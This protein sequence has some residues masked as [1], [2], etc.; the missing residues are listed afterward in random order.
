M[1]NMK[2]GYPHIDKPW[3]KFYGEDA[4]Y[5]DLPQTNLT[6]YLKMRNEGRMGL[7]AETYYGKKFT[8]NDLFE[9]SDE[10]ATIFY[11]LGI[12]PGESI[13]NLVPNIPEAGHLLN[14]ATEV[15]IISNFID[16]RPDTP[17][18]VANARKVLELIKY[19][20]PKYIIA[21]DMA[22]L[23]AIRPIE[24]ELKEYGVDT[25]ILLSASDSMNLAGKIDYLRDVIEYNRLKNLR[26]AREL[27]RMAQEDLEK[28]EIKKLKWYEALMEKTQSMKKSGSMLE[29]AIKASPLKIYRY[30]D[31]VRD[32]RHST[33]ERVL[34]PYAI[35]YVGHTSGTSG[36]RPKP[37]PATNISGISAL[38]QLRRADVGYKEKDNVLHILPYFAPFGKY[39][40]YD[41]HLAFGANVISIPEF[42]IA[43][44]GYLIKKYHPN[45]IVA[46]PAWISSLVDCEYLQNIDLSCITRI[47]YG[48]DALA[49]QREEVINEW[50]REHGSKATLEKGYGMSETLGCC[51]YA[52]KDYNT[53]GSIGIPLPNTTFAIVDPN[54]EDRLVPLKFEEGKDLLTGELV[55]SSEALTTGKLNGEVIVPHYKLDGKDCIR[56]RDIVH[57]NRDGIFF[58]EERKDRSFV[59]FDGFKVK[60]Y[61]IESKILEC[62]S[63]EDVC[64]VD[65]FDDRRRGNMPICHIVPKDKSVL[66]DDD[67]CVNIV[68]DIVYNY[69]I[70]DPQMSSRQIPAKF[71][72]HA[73]LPLTMSSKTNFNLLRKEELNDGEVNVDVDET[74]LNVGS[75][76]IYKVK[77]S[78]KKKVLK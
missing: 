32:C 30:S 68:N 31:L 54:I 76:H 9:K 67:A 40:N 78:V 16:P 42:E 14:G 27:E 4:V 38:E 56:T 17:D 19:E 62:P 18:L 66:E 2:T 58:H 8:Y 7:V 13:L 55:V 63:I 1:E 48:G 33:Y 57:M 64:L 73:S 47:I 34:D 10:A 37:I 11:Q 26:N 69:I 35:T 45:A 20:K 44:F 5:S 72:F 50:L 29:A 65:Y 53:L 41:N 6:E 71:K 39:D 22:Y 3:M 51:S 59:R 23:A 75:I 70:A 77:K 15:G 60:P 25:V 21:L 49:P 52:Q 24:K 74:N 43:E 28:I 61:N 46:T 36:L 12:K